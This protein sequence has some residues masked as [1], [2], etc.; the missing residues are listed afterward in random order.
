MDNR[1]RRVFIVYMHINDGSVA[2][3]CCHGVPIGC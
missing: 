3:V 2:G 1:I